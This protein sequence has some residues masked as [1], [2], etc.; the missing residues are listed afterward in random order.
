MWRRLQNLHSAPNCGGVANCFGIQIGT[1]SY[2]FGVTPYPNEN[3]ALSKTFSTILQP[4]VTY[5]LGM[6]SFA[7]GEVLHSLYANDWTLLE[8]KTNVHSNLCANYEQG[9][10]LGLYFGG[11]CVAPEDITVLYEAVEG[12]PGPTSNPTSAPTTSP[13]F[14]GYCS[15]G[16][17]RC[18]LNGGDVSTCDCS[19]SKTR[20]LQQTEVYTSSRSQLRRILPGKPPKTPPP[21]TSSPTGLPTRSPTPEVCVL[22]I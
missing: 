17:N 22:K 18:D 15:D 3:W 19:T 1:Y 6:E 7:N 14:S 12:P 10:V 2:D 4:D 11:T 20:N 21:A 16:S 9:S 5:V 13:T 8:A